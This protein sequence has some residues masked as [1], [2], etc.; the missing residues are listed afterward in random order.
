METIGRGLGSLGAHRAE[1]QASKLIAGG[2]W[3]WFSVEDGSCMGSWRSSQLVHLEGAFPCFQ[4]KQRIPSTFALAS[5]SE[6]PK[7]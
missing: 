5:C 4:Q 1:N 6:N 7:P 3:F 2:L